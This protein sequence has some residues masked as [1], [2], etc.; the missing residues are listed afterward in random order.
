MKLTNETK[1]ALLPLLQ[2][3]VQAK[4]DEWEAES[5]ME[6]VLERTFDGMNVALEPLAVSYDTGEQVTLEDVQSYVDSL[7]ED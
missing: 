6:G 5:A 7:E 1:A 3:A 4:I 2:K